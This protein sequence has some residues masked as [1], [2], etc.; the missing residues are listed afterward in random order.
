MACVRFE[1]RDHTAGPQWEKRA[2]YFPLQ[3]CGLCNNFFVLNQW[4]STA[5]RELK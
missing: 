3:A 5:A 2:G 4:R 1:W